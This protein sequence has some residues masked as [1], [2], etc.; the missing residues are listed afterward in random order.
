MN[1]YKVKANNKVGLTKVYNGY[2][3]KIVAANQDL[4]FIESNFEMINGEC[5]IVIYKI[6]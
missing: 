6:E 4:Y 3:P 2:L 5:K 1:Y